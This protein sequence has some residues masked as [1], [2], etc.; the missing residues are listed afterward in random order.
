M[1]KTCTSCK[2]A[3]EAWN[4]QCR[5]CGF[6]LVLEPDEKR[7]ARFLRGPALGALLFT[8]G[9]TFG[10]RV[11]F[12]F[13]ISLIPVVGIAALILCV[14][15]GRRWSWKYG[16]WSDWGEFVKRMRVMDAIGLC[17]VAIL[18]WAYLYVRFN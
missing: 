9:W 13:L 5:A 17:W 4:E 18:A 3:V 11:Y 12:W 10:A 2:N 1:S 7:R 6:T 16:G 15:F 14:I 8:Q